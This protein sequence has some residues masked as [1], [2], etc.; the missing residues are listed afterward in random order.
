MLSAHIAA[1][2]VLADAVR[3]QRIVGGVVIVRDAEGAWHR[4]ARGLADRER[5][6][7]MPLDAIFRLSSLTKP[8]VAMTV[9][10]MVEEGTWSLDD[11]IADYL[12]DF[13]PKAADGTQ[14]LI[15]LHHLLTHTSGITSEPPI[16][17]VD[18]TNPAF[19]AAGGETFHLSL[20]DAVQRLCRTPLQFSPG[21]GWAYSWGLDVLGA[22]IE[23]MTGARLGDAVQRL[24]TG[25]LGMKDTAFHAVDLARLVIPYADSTD[26]S[27]PRLMLDNDAVPNRRGGT[28]Y[29]FPARIH[30]RLG[31]HHAGGGMAGTADDF[32]T[33]LDCL[34][35]GGAP[36]ISPDLL[37]TSLAN[38]IPPDAMVLGKPWG[39]S[40][41]GAVQRDPQATGSSAPT[42]TNWWGG[43]FGHSWAFDPASGRAVVA[44][45][46]TGV[47]GW[48]GPFPEDIRHAVF[49]PR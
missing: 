8:I 14:P 18:E 44:L 3:D 35:R 15:S 45:T 12:P 49:G 13:R 48:A 32:M 6:Q 38:A 10:A 7:P 42:G 37:R 41:L 21:Q 4:T 25:P 30:D 40:C 1:Q 9:L 26:G 47:E 39:F 28:T 20:T 16:S 5:N 36:L 17:A 22:A 33:M 23:N 31:Y 2:N 43:I 27:A 29:F 46:N 11:A 24:V 34:A 19:I